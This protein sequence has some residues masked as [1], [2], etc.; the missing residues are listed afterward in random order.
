[1]TGGFNPQGVTKCLR[2]FETNQPP[3]CFSPGTL[4][5]NKPLQNVE[6]EKNNNQ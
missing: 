6:A 4:W 2:H 5:F 3:V 1:L